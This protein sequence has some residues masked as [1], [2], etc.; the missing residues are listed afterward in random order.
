MQGKT[1]IQIAAATALL[2]SKSCLI[3]NN[4]LVLTAGAIIGSLI[5]DID[6]KNSKITKLLYITDKKRKRMAF[7]LSAVMMVTLAYS[8]EMWNLYVGAIYIALLGFA[9]HRG[10]THSLLGMGILAIAAYPMR[11]HNNIFYYGVMLGYF[12]HLISDTFTKHGVELFYPKQKRVKFFITMTTGGKL[13][14]I[15]HVSL[16]LML[17]VLFWCQ[18]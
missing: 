11:A 1:H 7:I 6:H 17:L 15:L 4:A 18:I 9:K 13:E 8:Y 12:T 2:V 14:S 5:P 10:F 16:S 3:L